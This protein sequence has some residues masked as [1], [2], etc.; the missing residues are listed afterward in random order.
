MLAGCDLFGEGRVREAVVLNVAL[1]AL[2]LDRPWDHAV[3]NTAPDVY[4]DVK[5]VAPSIGE[6]PLVR[7]VVAEDVRRTSLPLTLRPA[8][9]RPIPVDELVLITV[10]DR[11]AGTFLDG[12]DEMFRS[13]TLRLAS[14]LR[15][16][17]RPGGGR[18]LTFANAETRMLVRVE[19]Q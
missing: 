15:P 13:D 4:V 12:D 3:P 17:D 7:S 14:L 6:S 18:T 11:D 10:A 5:K 16:E 8:A 9:S 2:P 19:W 1:E